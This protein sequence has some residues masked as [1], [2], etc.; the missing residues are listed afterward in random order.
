M[1]GGQQDS[2]TGLLSESGSL[3]VLVSQLEPG[4]L[5]GRGL[6]SG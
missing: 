4:T 5:M 3:S 6:A 2:V 1:V